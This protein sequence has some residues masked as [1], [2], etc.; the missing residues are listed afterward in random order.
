MNINRNNYE[1]YIIDYLDGNLSPAQVDELML[2][3]DQNPDIKEEI[4]GLENTLPDTGEQPAV[5]SDKAALKQLDSSQQSSIN[6]D[7]YETWFIAAVE[8]TLSREEMLILD[9][10]L[11]ENPDLQKDFDLFMAT[12]L[13]ADA[14]IT[15]QDK[16]LL[17]Q[18]EN[19]TGSTI[20]AD[21]FEAWCVAAVEGELSPEQQNE[22]HSYLQQN[23]E[24]KRE[25]S[26]FEATRLQ[27][28]MDVV[29][30][31]KHELKQIAVIP[32]NCIDATNYEFMMV[33]R[34]E[35][36]M[37]TAEAFAFSEFM[38]K[39]PGLKQEYEW[40]R[41]TRLR[42]EQEITYNA[43]RSLKKFVIGFSRRTV[44]STVGAAAALALLIGFSWNIMF[45][46]ETTAPAIADLNRPVFEAQRNV[47][48]PAQD[49]QAAD[50]KTGSGYEQPQYSETSGDEVTA[51]VDVSRLEMIASAENSMLESSAAEFS[52]DYRIYIRDL[53]DP[54]PL[55]NKVDNDVMMALDKQDEPQG[56]EGLLWKQVEEFTGVKNTNEFNSRSKNI[57]W[58]AVDLGLKGI[59]T[60]T[61]SELELK[62]KVNEEAELKGY[63][64]KSRN[65]EI[66]RSR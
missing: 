26:L 40:I 18:P 7:D 54:R 28:D 35:G 53:Y 5:F 58:T 57:F 6:R 51:R 38:E 30:E 43:K 55:R 52:P 14:N 50:D 49:Q 60:L 15:Y 45:P 13:E 25:Y 37:T 56:L 36:D 17:K 44:Y 46:P 12:K 20:N 27:P 34:M 29:F 61:G 42:N 24:L 47:M 65:F 33:A 41:K 39:N 48:L 9:D 4:D 8:G 2:F 31:N 32:V 22:L 11:S 23:P 21:S 66:S 62:R 16:D 3:L 64:I 63:K 59:N 19:E 10:F 1:I